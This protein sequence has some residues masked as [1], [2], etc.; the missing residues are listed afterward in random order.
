M[1][2]TPAAFE[3]VGEEAFAA[4]P[5]SLRARVENLDVVIEAWPSAVDLEAADVPDGH[6][7]F[8]LYTGIPLTERTAGYNMVLPDRITIFRGPLI[9]AFDD[10]QRLRAEIRK[11]V[12]HEIAHFFGLSDADL[13]RIGTV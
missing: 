9:D 1:S 7:L 4:I 13:D 11:T 12:I 10:V 6:T 5:S 8:G 2:L 3:A